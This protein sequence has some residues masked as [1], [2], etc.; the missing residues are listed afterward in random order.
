[1]EE[2]TANRGVQLP[3]VCIVSHNAYGAMRGGQSG[4][5][6]GVERQTSLLAKWLAQRGAEVS[7]LTWDEGGPPVEMIDHVRVIKIAPR[8][9]CIP[10]MRFFHPRWT[11]LVKAMRTARCGRFIIT[12]A[13]RL[14]LGQIGAV[15]KKTSARS[16]FTLGQRD[17]D[18]DPA[19]P[20]LKN[21]RDKAF[22]RSGLRAADRLI[23]QTRKQQA[24][25]KAGFGLDAM[26]L[27]MPC[28][29]LSESTLEGAT[30][31][32]SPRVL[33]IARACKQKRPDRLLD[34]AGSVPGN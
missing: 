22:Y 26:V 7:M 9:G 17:P 13:R 23:V 14:A 30:A 28:P 8:D 25:L 31:P 6:G 34:L 18:C 29:D 32:R 21:F 2:P 5:I 20:G 33:W 27:P 3:S 1:M 15:R 10:G 24:M 16:F 11:G 19:L 4:H 12:I